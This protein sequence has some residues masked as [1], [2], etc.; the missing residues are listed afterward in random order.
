[1]SLCEPACK[2]RTV[3]QAPLSSALK[4]S[5]SNMIDFLTQ[6]RQALESEIHELIEHN[7]NF[8]T[9]RDSL[10]TVTGVGAVTDWSLIALLPE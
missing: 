10:L 2:R 6:E 8:I 3:I 4:E 5:Y 9:K 1:M 7:E